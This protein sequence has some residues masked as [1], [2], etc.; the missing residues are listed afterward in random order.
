[1]LF[2]FVLGFRKRSECA[3]AFVITSEN[4][5]RLLYVHCKD[6]PPV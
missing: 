1:M 4:C 6:L 3:F 2:T 5:N